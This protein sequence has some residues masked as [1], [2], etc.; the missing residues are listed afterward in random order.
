MRTLI[1][2]LVLLTICALTAAGEKQK[3]TTNLK[4]VQPAGITDKKNK[5]QQFD[6]IFDA[7]GMH[8]TCRSS[9]KNSVKITDFVV[10]TDVNFEIDGNKTKLKNTAGKKVECTVVRVEKS[11]TSQK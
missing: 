3:G 2:V 10:G 6:F 7:S 4:D 5:N 1:A 9:H 11:A 8:Y